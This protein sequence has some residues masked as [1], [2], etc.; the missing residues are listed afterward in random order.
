MYIADTNNGAIR[1]FTPSTGALGTLD[2]SSVPKVAAQGGPSEQDKQSQA[3][4]GAVVRSRAGSGELSR[5]KALRGRGARRRI[6]TAALSAVS[7][8]GVARFSDERGA[9]GGVS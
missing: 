4:P 9:S 7:R 6:I 2:V 8:A 1:V 3:P 5:R